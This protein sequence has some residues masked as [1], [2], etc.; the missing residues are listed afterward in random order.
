LADGIT[1][2]LGYRLLTKAPG[3]RWGAVFFLVFYALTPDLMEISVSGME[4]PLVLL[5]AMAAATAADLERPYL[6]GAFLGLL[7]LTRL[8]GLL[9][10]VILLGAIGWRDRRLPWRSAGVTVMLL[11]PWLLYAWLCYGSVLPNSIPAKYAAYNI[12]THSFFSTV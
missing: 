2:A 11:A 10:A 5:F 7:G 1:A 4:T 8:D 9:F 12:H 3:R 6:T